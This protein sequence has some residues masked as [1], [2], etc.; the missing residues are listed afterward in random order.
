MDPIR[1][2]S[3]VRSSMAVHRVNAAGSVCIILSE[4]GCRL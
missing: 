1:P 4:S 2:H 3:V